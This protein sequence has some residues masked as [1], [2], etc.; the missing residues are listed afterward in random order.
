MSDVKRYNLVD[1]HGEDA[2]QIEAPTGEWYWHEDYAALAA[3]VAEL[4]RERDECADALDDH[5]RT[6][7]D[8]VS[9]CRSA[10]R[11]E[12]ALR[13]ALGRAESQVAALTREVEGLREAARPF[14][15]HWGEW[16]R[17]RADHLHPDRCNE[18]NPLW[19][20]YQIVGRNIMR[21]RSALAAADAARKIQ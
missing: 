10:V 3:R 1:R 14:A 18:S 16:I 4:E 21:L 8:M 17:A 5:W 15:E 19:R 9:A 13:I 20:N 2:T 11:S 12:V 7:P 6:N